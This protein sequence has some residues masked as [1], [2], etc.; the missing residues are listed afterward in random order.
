MKELNLHNVESLTYLKKNNGHLRGPIAFIFIY[1]KKGDRF[2][3]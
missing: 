1:S 2:Y 3:E